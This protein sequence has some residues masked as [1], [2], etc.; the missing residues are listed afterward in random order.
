MSRSLITAVLLAAIWFAGGCANFD[1]ITKNW[2]PDQLYREA[3]DKIANGDYATAIKY[4]ESLEARYPY[5]KYAEQAQIEI[6]YAYNKNNEPALAIAAADRFIRLHP[7]HPNVDYA[8]YLK[9]LVQFRLERSWIDWAI[10]GGDDLSDRDPK[11]ARD[12]YNTFRD[13]IERY[14]KSRY[15]PDAAA[16]MAFLFDHLANY[17]VRVA[18]FYYER[19]AYV[20]AVNRCKYTLENFPRA[21]SVE[22]AL[23]IQALAYHQ[24][25]LV[26]LKDDSVRILKNNFPKSLY[27]GEIA[28]LANETS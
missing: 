11:G 6:A 12:A 21:P 17:E 24:M 5:G 8:Y 3:K 28:K 18:R 16:R 7:T 2:G 15:A 1:D 26:H 23:G 19:G 22:D 27:L 10:G 13:L 25:G 4:F 9:G 14:P 20:A